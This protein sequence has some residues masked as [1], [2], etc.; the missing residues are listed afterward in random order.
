MTQNMDAIRENLDEYIQTILNTT[1]G[2]DSDDFF[3]QSDVK[4]FK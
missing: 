1:D 4:R 2:D 3:E